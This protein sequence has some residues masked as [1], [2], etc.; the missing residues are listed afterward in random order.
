MRKL[1]QN[2]PYLSAVFLLAAVLL[3]CSNVAMASGLQ[4]W[5][6]R[7]QIG[8]GQS[9]K[10]YLMAQA[11]AAGQP[12]LSPLRRNFDISNIEQYLQTQ[13]LNG[14]PTNMRTWQLTLAP[15][16]SGKLSVPALR[17]G[18]ANSAPLVLEVFP[19]AQV[20][21]NRVLRDVMLQT[22]VSQQR[23]Y[24]QGKVIYT[25]RLYTRLDLH[26][27]RF[28]EPEVSNTLVE[29]L[30]AD[31]KYNTY[32]GRYRYHVLQRSFALFPQRS[33]PLS[34]ISPLLNAQVREKKSQW[35][36]QLRGPEITLD[37][38]PQ[39]DA[40][41]NPWLP[42]ESLSL[43]ESWSPDPPN[44]R[45]GEPVKRSITITA[46]GV[47]AAQ[48]PDLEQST[49]QGINLYPERPV[50][51]TRASGH[52]LVTQ[53]MLNYALVAQREG[54][55]QLP[56]ISLT[57]W[58]ATTGERKTEMLAA[59]DI[60]VLPGKE[61]AEHGPQTASVRFLPEFDLD[62]DL[63]VWRQ[64]LQNAWQASS[65]FWPWLALVLALVLMMRLFFWWRRRHTRS[66]AAVTN[67]SPKVHTA[68]DALH[69]F[70][71]ACKENDPHRAREA[72][73]DWAA[74]T[75]PDDPPQRLDRLAH[76]LPTQAAD[77]LAGIDRALYAPTGDTWD[78]LETLA[79]LLPL[80]QDADS[81]R[82][83]KQ[84]TQALRPLYPG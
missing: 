68:G 28:T 60:V 80:L 23:P 2:R 8:E 56:G 12:D 62:M 1:L 33:G 65:K 70:E 16:Q 36:L 32:L 39:P 25:I 30:G 79:A 61:P 38:Q 49:P 50:S 54:N 4:A 31:T 14:R 59:R 3:S 78:G 67:P 10:L 37:V 43:S 48:L 15:K 64:S 83:D 5:L 11:D 42:A 41:L 34:I 81:D 24:V 17:V 7:T 71:G 40:S 58:D 47:A 29:H 66:S 51:S 13:V 35:P 75:W 20:P 46:Q 55:Y 19:S 9:V 18:Q 74:A 69:R 21:A 77:F 45:V 82:D 53:K 52:T 84:D 72:L 44:F 73:V 22:D 76:R 63:G 57:W 6:D 27:V 26:Q